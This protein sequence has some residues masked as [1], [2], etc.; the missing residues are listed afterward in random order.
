MSY[1][2][3]KKIL[4]NARKNHYAV[5]AFN[6][7]N[8]LTA[9]AAVEAAEELEQPIILQTSVKTVK[10]FGIT[11][12]MS[13][14]KPIAEQAKVEVAIHLDHSTDVAFTKACIDGGWSSVMYD[15][16]QLALKDNIKNT[17]E[18][19]AYA[20]PKQVTVEGELGAIVGVE[21]DIVVLAGNHAHAKPDDCRVYLKETEIDAFAPAVGTAH[22]VYKGEINIDYDLFDEIN[23]FSFCPLVLHGGTGLTDEMFHR[24]IALGASKVNISTAIKIAYV[25]GMATYTKLNVDQND[26]LKLDAFTKEQVKKVVTEHIRFFSLRN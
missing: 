24:L 1:V 9:K 13:F 20:K 7:V 4:D 3:M 8:Y 22:G 15:G 12:M 18:I 19:V 21:D 2:N 11:E 10:A 26:P 25:Q 14:L 17:K 6:I 16:S 5:G 23:Q